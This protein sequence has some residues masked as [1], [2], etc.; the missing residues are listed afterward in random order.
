MKDDIHTGHSL[1][2]SMTIAEI[3]GNYVQFDADIGG[4][5][6]EQAAVGSGVVADKSPHIGAQIHQPFGEMT[7]DEAPCPSNQDSLVRTVVV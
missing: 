3:A 7:A 2:H 4:Q 5:L 1:L 6:V